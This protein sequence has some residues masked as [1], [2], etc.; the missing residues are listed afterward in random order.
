MVMKLVE[1]VKGTATSDETVQLT[2]ELA[3]RIGKQ[4]VSG[5]HCRR[6]T[7]PEPS[8]WTG[9]RP[10]PPTSRPWKRRSVCR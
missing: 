10:I 2:A 7:R 1:V 9:K 4:P 8:T 5:G 3:R 6:K